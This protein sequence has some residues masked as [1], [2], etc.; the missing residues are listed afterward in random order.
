MTIACGGSGTEE[1]VAK[2]ERR[3]VMMVGSGEGVE[4]QLREELAIRVEKILSGQF[5][6]SQQ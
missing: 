5:C 3:G 2:S 6:Q 1:E 4:R